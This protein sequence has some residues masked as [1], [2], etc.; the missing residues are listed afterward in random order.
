MIFTMKK[1]RTV[2]GAAVCA[3]AVLL[4]AGCASTPEP[5]GFLS[6]YS[7]LEKTGPARIGFVSPRLA[8]YDGFI[9]DP[10]EFRINRDKP[11]LTDKQK[12]DIVNHFRTAFTKALRDMNYTIAEAPGPRVARLR[13]AITDVQK[14]KWYMNLHSATK[15]SGLGTGGASMEAEVI[16]S[17]SGEQLGGIIAAGKGNQ[18]ELDH[19][20][21]LDDVEDVIDG[22]A[23]LLASRIGELRDQA[24]Q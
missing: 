19:F 22:W 16:D 3:V 24:K 4:A 12:A 23:K 21:S 1:N 6:D 17:V 20:D 7:R 8:D 14:S 18:F 10:V 11:V 5:S 2:T 9:I 15:L 13:A